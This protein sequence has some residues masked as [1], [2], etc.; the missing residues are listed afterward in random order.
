MQNRIRTDAART[1]MVCVDRFENSVPKGR[2]YNYGNPDEGQVFHG[3]MDLLVGIEN[4]LD[5]SDYGLPTKEA[6]TFSTASDGG[7]STQVEYKNRRGE[8]AT[9]IV[10]VLFRQ[11]SSWQGSVVW[12]EE[13]CEEP[14]RS[15]LELVLLLESALSGDAE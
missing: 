2:F 12:Q 3:L 4:I 5:A 10:K 13:K 6:R 8:L 1:T 11:H 15:V 14:F 7:V 9:F